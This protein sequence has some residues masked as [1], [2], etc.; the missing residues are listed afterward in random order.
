MVTP[1]GG[2]PRYSSSAALRAF[3]R[4]ASI[5]DFAEGIV[6]GLAN[7]ELFSRGPELPPEP[8]WDGALPVL[9]KRFMLLS[10]SS[11]VRAVEDQRAK[12]RRRQDGKW[13]RVGVKV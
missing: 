1:F 6:R 5:F 4:V 11:H 13:A 10:A 9:A 3:W 8:L 7:E 2:W 12:T